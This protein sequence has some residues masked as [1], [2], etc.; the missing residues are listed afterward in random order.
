MFPAMLTGAFYDGV[1]RFGIRYQ[2]DGKL[3]NLWILKPNTKIKN[4]IF[5]DFL[6]ADDCPLRDGIQSKMQESVDVFSAA[7]EDFDLT[8]STMKLRSC[9]N[10]LLLHPIQ[11]LHHSWW[12]KAL[13]YAVLFLYIK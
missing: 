4:E 10:P 1:I 11:S 12:P 5:H 2:F 9:T 3:F 8:V 7:S 6:L 13:M